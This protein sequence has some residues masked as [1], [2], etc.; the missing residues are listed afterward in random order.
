MLDRDTPIP[1]QLRR[2]GIVRF[3]YLGWF[4]P[5]VSPTDID[6][7]IER[8][9]RFLFIENKR[10]G[11]EIPRGQAILFDALQRLPGAAVLIVEGNPVDDIHRARWWDPPTG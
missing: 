2:N 7:A 11:Q 9:G 6:Y 8:R 10:P 4:V 5:G 1:R 3:D